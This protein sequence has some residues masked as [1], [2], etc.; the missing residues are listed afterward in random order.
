MCSSGARRPGCFKQPTRRAQGRGTVAPAASPAHCKL[1]AAWLAQPAAG[2]PPECVAPYS[3]ALSRLPWPRSAA[4]DLAGTCATQMT[5]RNARQPTPCAARLPAQLRFADRLRMALA[6]HR[7]ISAFAPPHDQ[8]T[9]GM[10]G[11]LHPSSNAAQGK[12]TATNASVQ[13]SLV[14]PHALLHAGSLQL[15][16]HAASGR[17]SIFVCDQSH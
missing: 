11:T 16:T 7:G 17:L 10:L 4:P 5:G 9:N 12:P 8:A 15:C 14:V 3:L 1:P 6:C 2:G 13:R